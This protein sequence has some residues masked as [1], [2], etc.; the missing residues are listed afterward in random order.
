VF[1]GL[2]YVVFRA[3][4]AKFNLKTPGRED[5]EA[6]PVQAQT[7]DRTELAKQYLEVL[8]GQ[9]NLVTIDACITRLR[10]TLK[11]RSIV[12]ERK[13]KALGAAGV[14]KLGEQNLQVILG[15]LAEII[16]GEMKALR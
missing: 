10:L 4:I 13:L 1:F 8:G 3:V 14:V 2:Y 15:P 5:D 11:D 7:T 6:V 12:D 9:E 16:A